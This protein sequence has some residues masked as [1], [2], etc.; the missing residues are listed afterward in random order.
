MT[1]VMV[2]ANPPFRPSMLIYDRRY[3]SMTFQVIV[4]ILVMALA[5][6]LVNNTLRNL[7]AMGKDFDFGF[8]WQRAGYDIPQTPI[9][10]TSDDTHLR[11]AFVGLLNTL[12][13]SILGC[14]AATVVGIIAGVARLSNNWLIARLMTV[15]VEIFRNIPLL[16]WILLIYAVFTEA[17]PAP[18]AFR[19]NAETGEAA[20]SMFQQIAAAQRQ[21][22]TEL[23]DPTYRLKPGDTLWLVYV[24]DDKSVPAKKGNHPKMFRAKIEVGAALPTQP[25]A[26]ADDSSDVWSTTPA[27]T[28]APAARPATAA[29]SDE[30]DPFGSPLGTEEPP[31]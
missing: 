20:T 7:A 3:R 10:Y 22:R 6:W 16:L 8:L 23:G 4:F 17:A 11:A 13:V 1:D 12:I 18:N 14:I 15:Y 24:G 9:P 29:S 5:W 27:A 30:G 31:F 25:D 2:S 19:V 26:L 21:A 28:P